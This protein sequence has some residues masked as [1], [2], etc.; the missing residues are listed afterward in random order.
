MNLI[1]YS[2]KFL[3]FKRIFVRFLEKV[4]YQ[5][6]A[7][8]TRELAHEEPPYSSEMLLNLLVIFGDIN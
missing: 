2:R 3:I 5:E 1:W 8:D 4:D 7:R 6:S